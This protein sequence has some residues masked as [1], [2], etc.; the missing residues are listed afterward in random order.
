[1][2]KLTMTLMEVYEA[3]RS[4]GIRC[5]PKMISAG[6]ASGAYPFGRVVSIGDSGRRRIEIYRT[7][8]TA[9]LQSKTPTEQMEESA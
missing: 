3:M 6:I 2:Q 4:A 1:M 8:F 9:W 7:D 5:S